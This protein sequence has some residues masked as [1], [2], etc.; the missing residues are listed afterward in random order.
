M[1]CIWELELHIH[2]EDHENFLWHDIDSVD[3]K[4]LGMEDLSHEEV[5]LKA[6][7]AQKA[8]SFDSYVSMT[9]MLHLQK[10]RNKYH[11]PQ[12]WKNTIIVT[13]TQKMDHASHVMHHITYSWHIAV[14]VIEITANVLFTINI[15]EWMEVPVSRIVAVDTIFTSQETWLAQPSSAYWQ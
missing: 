6:Y 14:G 13:V 1:W 5:R 4:C 12:Y 7:E 11:M 10:N 15:L 9:W 8:G 3:W 2:L